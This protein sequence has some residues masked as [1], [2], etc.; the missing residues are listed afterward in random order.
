MRGRPARLVALAACLS[1]LA[2]AGAGRRFDSTHVTDIQKAVQDKEQIRAWFGEP[3]QVQSL[4]DHPD[5]CTERW[6]SVHAF[7]SYGGTRT[8]SKSLVV[9]S[10]PK[11]LVCDHAY[12]EK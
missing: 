9:D 2:C 12:V 6:T 7:A 8:E 3:V 10:E 1:M 4:S 11:G 5:G